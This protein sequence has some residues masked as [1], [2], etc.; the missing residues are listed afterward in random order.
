MLDHHHRSSTTDRFLLD[1]NADELRIAGEFLSNWFPFLSRDF[2]SSCTHTLSHRIRSL[3]RREAVGDAEQLKQQENF[4]VLTP[5]LPDS[6]AC[7]GNHD[8]CYG[9][10]LG[11]WQDCAV[12]NG[13][14]DTNSLGSWKDG[15]VVQEPFDDALTCRN[16]SNSY[17]G[18]RSLGSLKGYADLNDTA[19]TNSLGSWK[20]G[21]DVQEPFDEALAPRNKS[22]NNVGGAVHPLGSWKDYADL[23]DTADT[24]S[25]GSW[26]DGADV[27]EPFDEALAH[28]NKSDSY[29][30]VA[31]RPIGSWKDCADLNDNVDT[32][33]LGSWKDSADVQ[34]PFEGAL[35]PRIKPDNY[36]GGAAR[37][38]KE[39]SRSKTF[40]SSR[41]TA[42]WRMKMPLADELDAVEISES[43]I[44][45]SQ[46]RN[47][48]GMN[49][50]ETSVQGAKPKMELSMEQ[51]EHIRFCNVKRKKDFICLERVNG[52][53]VN[54][55]DGLELHTG[56]FSMA[57]QNRIVK[58]VEKLE[59]I[60]KSGQLKERTYTAPQKWMRGKGR[61]T[62]Q[63][64]CCY[65]YA[66]DKKGNS[67]GILKSETVD[68]LPDLLKSMVRRLVRWHV[69]PPDCVPDSCI[70]NIY[71]VGDCI[72]PHID[73]HDF[74]RPFCTVSFLSECNV[75][76]G[77]NLKIVGPGDFAGAIAIPL[78]MGSV[79]VLNGNG[80]DVAK[81][82]VPAVP[83]KR[84]SITFR[85]MNESRRPIGCAPEQDLLGL[86]PISHE[87]DR[88][89]K[90]KT[91]KPWHSK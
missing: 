64:G 67:P 15:A 69:L 33:S 17:V 28:R 5:E 39:A 29:I 91:Y 54:I 24:N 65:N 9:N 85:R 44:C 72:P 6:N 86:Q 49:K 1:Y 48:N 35:T 76:F 82:C 66:T 20:D 4:V 23:N 59:E 22:D 25:L 80:A 10:S 90:S 63:F 7:N 81:H 27:Q 74:F 14:A 50:E 77:S 41:P 70:V 87:A 61:A 13:S 58:F 40:R 84:I 18:G 37:P 68:P 36:L 45:S 51:R 52:K 56:V 2:C 11:S 38:V 73:S 62:I 78:P 43:S 60:G 3:G 88:Y 75:V 8:N 30:G 34:E 46:L 79:L 12:L 53:I 83:T 57:E 71:D 31:D 47:G 19:D 89:E 16:K 21:A 26:K 55:L 32:N 42:I